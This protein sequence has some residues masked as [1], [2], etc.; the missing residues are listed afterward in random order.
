MVTLAEEE[1]EEG[2]EEEE[3]EEEEG[4]V[5]TRGACSVPVPEDAPTEGDD[6]EE[7]EERVFVSIV[8]VRIVV[9]ILPVASICPV[10][11]HAI[12]VIYR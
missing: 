10:G 11:D 3:D 8:H 2:S 7:E 9:S 12:H 5:T 1:E 4:V 6:G